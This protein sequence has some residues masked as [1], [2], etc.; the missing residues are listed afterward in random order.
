ME[1]NTFV[2]VLVTAI[3]VGFLSA[4]MASSITGNAI[5]GTN[6][7]TL[8]LTS[9][10]PSAKFGGYLV[11]LV[12]ASKNSASNNSATIKVTSGNGASELKEINEGSS[13]DINGLKIK[14]LTADETN[15]MLSAKIQ[16]SKAV[17]VSNQFYT[18]EEIN[19]QLIDAMENVVKKWSNKIENKFNS[20]AKGLKLNSAELDLYM[21]YLKTGKI[22]K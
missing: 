9:D 18:K 2:A 6:V 21:W 20:I 22:L 3:V 12:S 16:V 15:S 11:E 13:K 10:V 8:S 17:A 7:K 19:E 14:I 1:K 5:F 4:I